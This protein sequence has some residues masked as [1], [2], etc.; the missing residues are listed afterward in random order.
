MSETGTTLL[1]EA[2]LFDMDGTLVDSAAAID[3]VW[4]QFAARHGISPDA[5]RAALPGRVA[6]DI[7]SMVLPAGGDLDAELAWLR[8]LEESPVPNVT[9]IPGARRLLAGLPARRWAVVTSASRAMARRR[10]AAAGLPQPAVLICSEDVRAGKPDPEGF[11]AAAAGLGAGIDRCVAFEDSPT[12]L[13]AARRSGAIPVAVGGGAAAYA[14][15]D[16]TRVTVR[17]AGSRL[18]VQVSR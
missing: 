13:D 7:I 12:G 18:E 6:R 3:A 4:L 16:L 2:L 17:V 14:V 10:L 11:L 9:E 15:T 1:A 8:T 5:V